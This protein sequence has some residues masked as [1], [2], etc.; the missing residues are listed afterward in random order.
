MRGNFYTSVWYSFSQITGGHPIPTA[1]A[2]AL[3][4]SLA[5]FIVI[6]LKKQPK[7]S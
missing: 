2:L 6:Q 5:L 7:K 4:A 1:F 3:L